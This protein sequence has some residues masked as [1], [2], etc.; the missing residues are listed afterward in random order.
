MQHEE[1]GL[2]A[3]LAGRRLEIMAAP[4]R[5]G[6]PLSGE[7]YWWIGVGLAACIMAEINER[8]FQV[9]RIEQLIDRLGY[10]GRTGDWLQR[11]V[12]ELAELDAEG[13]LWPIYVREGNQPVQPTGVE[14]QP[15]FGPEEAYWLA[16]AHVGVAVSVLQENQASIDQL[17][18]LIIAL[19]EEGLAPE[20]P[21]L[22]Q[23]ILS[24]A[25]A[26][27]GEAAPEEGEAE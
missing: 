7:E 19:V 15:A 22:I 12:E 10:K 9:G 6:R 16:L 24:A 13:L 17:T 2:L 4:D 8:D 21:A 20:H 27:A 3:A 23:S 26:A 14:I 25:E 11:L 1:S 18:E 5:Y